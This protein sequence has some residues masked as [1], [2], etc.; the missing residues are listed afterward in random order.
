MN[1]RV[2]VVDK[3]G[4]GLHTEQMVGLVEAVMS[5]EAAEGTVV[6]ALV[7]ET[8]ML[9]LNRRHLG[10]SEPTDVLSFCS[11]DEAPGWPPEGEA[12]PD[13]GEVVVCPDVVRRYAAEDGCSPG[14]QLGWTI[15]HGLL[16]LLGYD[17]ERDD[18]EMRRRERALLTELEPLVDSLS[19][20]SSV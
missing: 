14:R 12:L 19:L 1:V 6:V 13:L 2:E 11:A 4:L 15:V 16:H 9:E 10:L 3:T 20:T 17:H 18:G 5:A 7:D 8:A